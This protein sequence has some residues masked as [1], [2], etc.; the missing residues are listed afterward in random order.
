MAVSQLKPA[1]SELAIQKRTELLSGI[2]IESLDDVMTLGNVLAKSGYF[3]DA[4]EAGQAVV[5]ILAGRELGFPPI[6]SMTGVNIIKGKVS[7]SANLIAAAIKRSG[8]YDYRVKKLTDEGCEIAFFENGQEVG[9]ASFNKADAIAAGL[10]NNENYKKFPR[11][12]YFSRTI[13]SGSRWYCPD[14]SGGAL[15]TPDELG[16]GVDGETGEIINVTPE[17]A[18][19]EPPAEQ[20]EAIGSWEDM[21]IVK[22]ANRYE[23]T[24]GAEV[25]TI[26]KGY[27]CTCGNDREG[28]SCF[29][30]A[31]IKGW[32]LVQASAPPPIDAEPEPIED[33]PVDNEPQTIT[34][35]QLISLCELTKQ[36]EA[37]GI[38][39]IT[40]RDQLENICGSRSRKGVMQDELAK[41]IFSFNNAL[42]AQL[43]KGGKGRAK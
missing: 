21:G 28:Q 31:A 23:V 32:T 8:R 12:M 42:A 1:P 34:K 14:L 18:Q 13:S 11:N 5:K 17:P 41:V 26:Q 22:F 2:R 35:S 20:A 27:Y 30:R 9:I 24:D 16:L 7:L 29:H 15:Y 38:E 33:P 19:P 25:F 40:W 37:A 10:A 4:R 3:S 39:E 43:R 6:A 36:M